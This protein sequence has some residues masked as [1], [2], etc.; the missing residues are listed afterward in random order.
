MQCFGC[1][2]GSRNHGNGRGPGPAQILVREVEDHLIVGV[3]M[4]S[5]HS[6]ADNLKFVVHDFR[7]GRQAI[8][9]A[10]GVRNNVML[11]RVIELVIHSQHHG[12][13]F[14]FRRRGDDDLLHRSAQMLFGVT[15]VG[16]ASGGFDH[17]LGTD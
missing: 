4:D 7:D 2:G 16:K 3:G 8:R 14:I 17:Y 12:E 13:V 5:G 15:G 9:G 11:G 6:S 1:A 10:G